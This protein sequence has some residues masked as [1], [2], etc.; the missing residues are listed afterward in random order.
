MMRER[1]L[2]SIPP[3]QGR[4]D[5]V[6]LAHPEGSY[7]QIQENSSTNKKMRRV[8]RIGRR[9][10]TSQPTPIPLTSKAVAKNT[11]A[12]R[13][14]QQQVRKYAK[15]AKPRRTIRTLNRGRKFEEAVSLACS[16]PSCCVCQD[17]AS[18]AMAEPSQEPDFDL[19]ADD[20]PLLVGSDTPSDWPAAMDIRSTSAPTGGDPF[21]TSRTTA[22]ATMV[23]SRTA[24]GKTTVSSRTTAGGAWDHSGLPPIPVI[25]TMPPCPWRPGPS[26][27]PT[28]GIASSPARRQLVKPGRPTRVGAG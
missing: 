19:H 7:T 10:G 14:R 16:V 20:E 24:A 4:G 18:S 17:A 2:Q 1:F 5:T 12:L 27:H 11:W 15:A 6:T 25:Y 22:E 9:C 21:S 3:Q 26:S 23:P 8:R 13:I 28:F